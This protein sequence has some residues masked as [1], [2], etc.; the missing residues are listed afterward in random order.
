MQRLCCASAVAGRLRA[1]S[2][3]ELGTKART[4]RASPHRRWGGARKGHGGAGGG[5]QPGADQDRDPAG[6][7]VKAIKKPR[8]RQGMEWSGPLE[9]V[10]PRFDS[11]EA[12]Y[13]LL[14]IQQKHP[15]SCLEALGGLSGHWHPPAQRPL[16][17]NCKRK[18]TATAGRSGPSHGTQRPLSGTTGLPRTP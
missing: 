3:L 2:L 10:C 15:R 1:A 6:D 4:G 7:G 18:S 8:Q 9:G 11:L 12:I 13:Y 14:T 5:F 17:E 16:Q